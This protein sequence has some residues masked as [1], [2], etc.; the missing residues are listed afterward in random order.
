MTTRGI[1]QT[2]IARMA[3]VTTSAVANWRNRYADF[4]PPC[5][6][7]PRR[8]DEV[9]VAEWLKQR[10]VV[11]KRTALIRFPQSPPPPRADLLLTFLTEAERR[12]P[13]VWVPHEV[14]VSAG[15]ATTPFLRAMARDGYIERRRVHFARGHRVLLRTPHRDDSKVDVRAVE[16]E[17]S[18][19][20]A[21]VGY[22]V[23]IVPA[24]DN[25]D[26]YTKVNVV[27][28]GNVY[29]GY[30]HKRPWL[31]LVTENAPAVP[32]AG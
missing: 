28:D 12:Q 24:R 26:R 30:V 19:A 5:D 22:R 32:D 4:P 6:S 8:F 14:I 1:R 21:A 11:M 16:Q 25:I 17:A 29:V 31:V 10:Q 20:L 13:G 27:Y 18:A 7:N 9:A 3:G 23:S 2:D 15:I